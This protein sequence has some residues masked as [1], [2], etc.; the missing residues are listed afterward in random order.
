MGFGG[1]GGNQG[2]PA[3]LFDGFPKLGGG[4]GV[5]DYQYRLRE[6]EG[7]WDARPFS[8]YGRPRDDAGHFRFPE[9]LYEPLAIGVGVKPV[10]VVKNQILIVMEV[11][12]DVGAERLAVAL[13]QV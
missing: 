4:P 6:R 10:H 9:C 8:G 1:G 11:R 12:L 3:P 13:Y 5:V 7:S 2:S